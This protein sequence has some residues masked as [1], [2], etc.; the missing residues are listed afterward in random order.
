MP[1]YAEKKL[2]TY[3]PDKLFLLVSDIEKYPEFLPWCRSLKII[4]SAENI[5]D[6]EMEIGFKFVREQFQ[7]RVILLPT[8]RIDVEYLDG[9]FRHLRNRWIFEPSDKGGCI[10]DFFVDFE[11]KSIVLQRVMDLVFRDAMRKMIQAFEARAA[12]LYRKS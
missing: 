10:I 6:A 4:N 2:L 7:T 11:F 8:K 12:L 5:V 3:P 9:P 1:V